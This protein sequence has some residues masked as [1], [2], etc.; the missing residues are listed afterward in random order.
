MKK[1]LRKFL[2]IDNDVKTT[3]VAITDIQRTLSKLTCELNDLRGS[4][5][6]HQNEIYSLK[7]DVRNN[8]DHIIE[9]NDKLGYYEDYDLETMSS[10]LDEHENTITSIQHRFTTISDTMDELLTPNNASSTINDV[11]ILSDENKSSIKE[12]VVE[13]ID[14]SL[15]K[16]TVAVAASLQKLQ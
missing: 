3:I 6:E 15:Q 11:Y 14:T 12:I 9:T 5:S 8:Y 16:Y 13:Q 10:I 1:F 4:E 7:T 2:L